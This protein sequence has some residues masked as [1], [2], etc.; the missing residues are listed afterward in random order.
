VE[1]ENRIEEL[2]E[3]GFGVT[4]QEGSGKGES[5][6]AGVANVSSPRLK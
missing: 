5:H 6:P 1:L 2:G 3:V 4:Y